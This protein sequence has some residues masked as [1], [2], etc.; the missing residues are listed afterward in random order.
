MTKWKAIIGYE[1]EYIGSRSQMTQTFL[2]NITVMQDADGT[3][4]IFTVPTENE[5]KYKHENYT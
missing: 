5:R 1:N 2:T 4:E 3:K